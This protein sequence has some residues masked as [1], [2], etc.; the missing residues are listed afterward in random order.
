MAQLMSVWCSEWVQGSYFPENED[1][2]T[3]GMMSEVLAFV[4]DIWNTWY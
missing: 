2:C 4:I 3:G 1:V